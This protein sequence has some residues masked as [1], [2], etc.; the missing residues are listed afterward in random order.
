MKTYQE[1]ARS[2]GGGSKTAFCELVR[3][4]SDMAKAVA[5]RRL[6]DPALAEDALQDAFLT[7]WLHLTGLRNPDAFPAWLRGIV[8]NSCRRMLR[9][10]PP[11]I[12]TSDLDNIEDL[13]SD[14]LDPWEHYARFQTRDMI[15]SL[16]ASLPGVYREAAVQRY[17]LGRSYEDIS[18]ALGVPV[19]TIKRRL[20]DTRERM[21]RAIAGHDAQAIRVGCLPI[22]DHL[23]P[24]I[25]QQR[26]DQTAFHVSLRRFTSWSE[27]AKAMVNE[28]LDAAMMMAPLTMVLHN[29]G[30]PLKWALDGHHEGSAITMQKSMIRDGGSHGFPGRDL[31]GA[32][33]GLPHPLSTHGMLLRSVLGLGPGGRPFRPVYLSPSCMALPL[34]RRNLDGFFCSEPWGLMAENAGTGTVLI[35]SHDLAPDHVCCILAVRSDF[36]RGKPE[37]LDGYLKLL[38]AAAGYVHA[39]PTESAAIQA[40]FT[41]VNRDAAAL[42]LERGFV[43]F[44]DLSPDSARARQVM[45]MALQSGILDRPCDLDA[46]L[47]P[48]AN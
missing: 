42:V 45:G 4:F 34:A 7:A 13:P 12:L 46:L 37:L 3:R 47:L 24:M 5:L 33:M 6:R 2:A 25:A 36:A 14:D 32:T 22:S 38:T 39:H 1:L 16:L 10:H 23:L 44:R 28:A 20:H 31:A 43:T 17:L 15:R 29:R 41:G 40:R 9:A 48:R 35:R 26:H 8:T 11:D 27:L 21:I 30:V 18:S 19:G